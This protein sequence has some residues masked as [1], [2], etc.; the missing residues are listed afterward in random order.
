ME[1]VIN[2]INSKKSL[3]KVKLYSIESIIEHE[4]QIV[5]H[6]V[7]FAQRIAKNVRTIAAEGRPSLSEPEIDILEMSIWLY[8]AL[9][10]GVESADKDAEESVR[11]Y[12]EYVNQSFPKLLK[13]FDVENND[14]ST[15]IEVVK[16]GLLPTT[17]PSK[18]QGV[19]VDSLMMD[20]KGKNAKE[21]LMHFY[22]E[23]ILSDTNLSISK[24]Y[25]LIIG[26]L[27]NYKPFTQY[28]TDHVEPSIQRL[29]EKLELEKKKISKKKSTIIKK[30]LDISDDEFKEIRK[31][32]NTVKGRDPRG[33]QTLFRTTSKNHY[34]LNEMVDRKA[35]IMITVNAII[36][37]LALSDLLGEKVYADIPVVIPMVILSTASL[38]SIIFAVISITPSKTQGNF[39]SEDVKKKR[40]NLLYYGNFRR[41]KFEDY[42]RGMLDKLNDSDFLYSSMIKDLYYLG[43]T[44]DHKYNFIR[45]S[46]TIFLIGLVCAFVVSTLYRVVMTF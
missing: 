37:S 38:F 36:L 11:F 28:A 44:L 9:L 13:E 6:N 34:T 20:F 26:Y 43:K 46:L 45:L 16:T 21:R 17:K 8:T 12:I 4:D 24:F 10:G 31:S 18:L 3:N 40:S 1:T 30:Q 14:A 22:E 23:T 39:T 19:F 2:K 5:Y 33:I 25:D 7:S 15:I 27:E 41:M 32:L 42:E 29:I 35:N